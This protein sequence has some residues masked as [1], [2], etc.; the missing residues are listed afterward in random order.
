MKKNTTISAVHKAHKALQAVLGKSPT[1]LVVAVSGGADSVFLLHCLQTLP[2]KK[3][4]IVAHVNHKTRGRHSDADA[5]FVK[6]LAKK[7]GLEYR[8]K[9]LQKIMTNRSGNSEDLWRKQR[10]EFF[11]S[12][13]KEV[14]G[15]W[16]VTAHHLS[17]NLETVLLNLIRGSFLDG[18]SG[19]NMVDPA[20]C[21]LRPLLQI[22][23][24]NIIQE[25]KKA[26]IAWR[27]DASNNNNDYSRNM[28][29]NKV[30][31]LLKE[32]NPN[33]ETTIMNNITQIQQLKETIEKETTAWV[34]SQRKGAGGITQEE[35]LKLAAPLQKQVIVHMY[36]ETYGSTTKLTGKHLEQLIQ[37]ATQKKSNISKEFGP[38]ATLHIK[39]EAGRRTIRVLEK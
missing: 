28:L 30:V 34:N 25:L 15:Q 12:I 36:K 4:V 8:E 37:V 18:M 23:K 2:Q 39:K 29:R 19:M 16:I 13:R 21:L 10:Y 22:T 26:A 6:N 38:R 17:D 35:F 5:L 11:E 1:T 20:R 9:T 32:I 24:E 14:G 33:L 3:R 7:Y 31:P 27:T